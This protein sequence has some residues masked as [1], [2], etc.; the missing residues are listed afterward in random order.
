LCWLGG[1]GD[2]AGL[3]GK[4]KRGGGQ[5]SDGFEGFGVEDAEEFVASRDEEPFTGGDDEVC[6]AGRGGIVC[7]LDGGSGEI[8][9]V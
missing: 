3:I 5:F 6:V 4:Y 7:R 9:F 1:G 2:Y 8:V